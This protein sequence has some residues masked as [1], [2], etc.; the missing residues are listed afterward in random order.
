MNNESIHDVLKMVAGGKRDTMNLI[1]MYVLFLYSNQV[2]KKGY[3]D[4]FGAQDTGWHKKYV[5][6]HSVE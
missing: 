1:V 3:L 5:V 4:F 6:S 2:T